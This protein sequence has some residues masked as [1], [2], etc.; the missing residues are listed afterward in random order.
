MI[1]A[2]SPLYSG[3]ALVPIIIVLI[4]SLIRDGYEDYQ[5]TKFD[6]SQ[7]NILVKVYRN[8]EW[9]EIPSSDLE[10][11]EIIYVK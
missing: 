11:G 2:I 9:T 1:P 4:I 8:N 3:A 7:N 6:K 5:R 10:M